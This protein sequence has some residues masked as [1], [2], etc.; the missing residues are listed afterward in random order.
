MPFPSTGGGYQ[1]NDG[2]LGE[3]QLTT[4]PAAVVK[5]AAATLT[6]AEL[7]SRIAAVTSSGSYALTTPTAAELDAALV[8]AKIGSTFDFAICHGTTTNVITLTG[9]TGVTVVGLATVT[10][11]TS[12]S[13]TFRKTGTAAWSAYRI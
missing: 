12:G 6:V 8:G 4:M 7:T 9:G 11:V 5:T 13:F 3:I 1:L 2:N 10:G